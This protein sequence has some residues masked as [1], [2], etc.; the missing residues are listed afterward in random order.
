M[1]NFVGCGDDE[2]EVDEEATEISEIIEE[3]KVEEINEEEKQPELKTQKLTLGNYKK[4][5]NFSISQVEQNA[6]LIRHKYYV[7]VVYRW[8]RNKDSYYCYGKIAP[9]KPVDAV[10]YSYSI[11]SSEYTIST[12]F[13]LKSMPSKSDYTFNGVVLKCYYYNSGQFTMLI[14]DNGKGET[15]FMVSEKAYSAQKSY[16]LQISNLSV[17]PSGEVQYYEEIK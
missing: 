11:I 2:I 5:L 7:E 8:N 1:L 4:F 10:E 9:T 17:S 3:D 12:K 15:S 6:D 13:M 14:D 16:N